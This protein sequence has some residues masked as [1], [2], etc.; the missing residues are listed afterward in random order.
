MCVGFRDEVFMV[1]RKGEDGGCTTSNAEGHMS[2]SVG[3]MTDEER[4]LVGF[5]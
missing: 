5:T 1:R 2:L 4:I 3:F